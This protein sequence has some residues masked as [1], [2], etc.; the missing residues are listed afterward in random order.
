FVAGHSS[1]SISLPEGACKA[2]AL[3]G[4]KRF[5]DALT[6]KG[7]LSAGS[8]YEA[9]NEM[10]DSKS[11]Y[12]ILFNDNEMKITKPIETI[13]KYLSQAMATQFYQSFKKRIAKM[14]DILPDSA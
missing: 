7:A 10:G 8:A 6:G 9:L 4:E 14:L 2:N 13:S 11:P 12:I 5:P 3:A 1:T